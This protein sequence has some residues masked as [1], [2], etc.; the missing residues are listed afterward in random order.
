M[1]IEHVA[2][3]AGVSISTVSNALNGRTGKMRDE[4]LSR[5]KAVIEELGFQPSRAA[6]QLKTGHTPLIGLLVPSIANPSYGTLAR[7]VEIAAQARFGY[8]VL[9]GNTYRSQEKEA[10]FFEDLRSHG[11]RGVIVV[12]SLADQSHVHS[13]IKRG[14]VVVSYDRRAAPRVALPMD[15]VSM[16]NV[17]AGRIAAQHLIDCGH[18]RLAFVTASGRTLSRTDK[19]NGFLAAARE[20]GLA[21]SASVIEHKTSTVYGDS[22]MAELGGTLAEELARSKQ[23]P[24]GIVAINDMLAI[25]LI[26]GLRNRG[27]GV[28]EM[29]SV[30]GMDDL[31]LSSLVSPTVTSIRPPLSEMAQTMVARTIERLADP[32]IPTEEFLF[33]PKLVVRESVAVRGAKK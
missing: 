15:Y 29:I 26:A 31:F 1:T 4:T 9:L 25:G 27:V 32:K 30:I 20:A 24:T 10:S 23:R 16:D 7:E 17:E 6:R 2:Q 18:R 3:R 12:S 33:Q 13:A 8:R 19:I 11:V 14:L 21:R 22:E 5:I 28:P